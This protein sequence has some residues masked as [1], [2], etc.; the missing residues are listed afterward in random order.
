MTDDARHRLLSGARVSLL[1]IEEIRAAQKEGRP[2]DAV[3]AHAMAIWAQGELRIVVLQGQI[4]R[5][6]KAG[7]R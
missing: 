1:V 6:R 4:E 2:F 3:A 7:Y 5:K